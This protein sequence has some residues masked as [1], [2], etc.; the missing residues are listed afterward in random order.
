MNAPIAAPNS[1]H[2]PSTAANATNGGS[3]K[4]W[5]AIARNTVVNPITEPTDRSMPPEMMTNVM[6]TATI[7]RNALSVSRSAATRTEAIAGNCSAHSA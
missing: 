2:T 1:A 5:I 7:P 3:A 4:C 6:P